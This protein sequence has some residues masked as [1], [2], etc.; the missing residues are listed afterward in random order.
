MNV[1]SLASITTG[2]IIPLGLTKNNDIVSDRRYNLWPM[3]KTTVAKFGSHDNIVDL[4]EQ[5]DKIWEYAEQGTV[6]DF[7]YPDPEAT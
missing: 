3:A 7:A 6:L 5:I 1:G 2:V 4:M